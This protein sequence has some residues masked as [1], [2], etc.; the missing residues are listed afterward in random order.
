MKRKT[1]RGDLA[2]ESHER[3]LRAPPP[4]P[5][6]SSA[7]YEKSVGGFNF[8]AYTAIVS[9]LSARR[10][11]NKRKSR[12]RPWRER[13]ASERASGR[14]QRER[15]ARVRAIKPVRYA[16]K[17]AGGKTRLRHGSTRLDS[18]VPGEKASEREIPGERNTVP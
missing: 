11:A 2:Q 14:V 17:R 16:R 18:L 4:P 3:R 15:R 1:P 5:P 13:R 9:R 7:K 12:A 6:C 10:A 8:A